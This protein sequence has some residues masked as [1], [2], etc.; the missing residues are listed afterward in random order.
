M[1]PSSPR[2]REW[3]RNPDGIG[4]ALVWGAIGIVLCIALLTN[5]PSNTSQRK[6]PKT[7]SKEH[8]VKGSTQADRD[9][10]KG[11]QRQPKNKPQV[12][13]RVVKLKGETVP[14]GRIVE[15]D[16]IAN[17]GAFS[18]RSLIYEIKDTK[19]G[20]YL[21]SDGTNEGWVFR[22]SV[23]PLTSTP[24]NIQSVK[25][26]KVSTETSKVLPNVK[27]TLG[28]FENVDWY[29]TKSDVDQIVGMP[30]QLIEKLEHNGETIETYAW[31][32][33]KIPSGTNY[34]APGGTKFLSVT[35][36]ADGNRRAVSKKFLKH[37]KPFYE[38]MS[39]SDRAE[40]RKYKGWMKVLGEWEAFENAE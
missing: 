31:H 8:Q 2:S 6:R 40:V 5:Q 18:D 23:A 16:S 20:F 15:R 32:R 7:S 22:S 12:A 27:I 34:N 17:E 26:P 29:H 33:D 30:G 1:P 13:R 28:M 10:T 38:G 11:S 37:Y 3:S 21:L 4:K 39:D 19:D 25:K 9:E 36:V 14:Y 35:F 24:T